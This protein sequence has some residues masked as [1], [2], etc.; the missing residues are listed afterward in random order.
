[1]K[2]LVPVLL[3]VLLGHA[4]SSRAAD[5][6][7]CTAAAL[8]PLGRELKLAHFAASPDAGGKDPAGIVIAS[9]CK[10]QPD[11]P[12][13]TLIAAAWDAHQEDSKA[14]AIAFV[15][16]AAGSVVAVLRDDIPEDATTQVRETSLRLD[17]APYQLAPGV[18]AFGLDI[19]SENNNCGDGGV[20]P[21]RTLYVREGRTLR[22][23][24]ANLFMTEYTWIRGNQ[25]RC[26][27]DPRE[28]ATAILEDRTVTIGLGAPGK[29][30]W[31]DL[32]LTMTPHRSDHQPARKPLRVTVPYDGREYD[33]KTYD[34]AATKWRQ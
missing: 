19:A 4:A 34:Q 5:N 9:A 2:R 31:R 16:E 23:V 25:P 21:M 11:D 32:V 7:D 33:L 13:L 26:V 12:R 6:Q 20:G 18:R 17:T 28:A 15:D 3:A 10:R 22:P 8:G 29:G 24:L 27:A 1:M 30:G 14:L